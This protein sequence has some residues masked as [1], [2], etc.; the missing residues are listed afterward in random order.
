MKPIAIL[1]LIALFSSLFL[2]DTADARRYR[3]SYRSTQTRPVTGY[4][5]NIHRNAILKRELRRAK[6][7]KPV[8]N[9]G[10]IRWYR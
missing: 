7:G 9:R 8:R 4:G 5:A 3:R 6:Q 2:V 1:A 10:N